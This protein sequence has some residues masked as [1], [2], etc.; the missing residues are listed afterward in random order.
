MRDPWDPSPDEI[1]QWAYTVNAVEPCEDWDLA[2]LWSCH[3]KALLEC[4]SDDHCPNRIYMLRIL[5]LVVG[6]AVRSDFRSRPRPVIDGLI[7]R[8]DSY[9]HPSI[10]LWQQRSRELL[11][12]P[13]SFDYKAWCAGSHDRHSGS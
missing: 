1:R 12:D 4:A 10:R 13:S 8:G 2:L 7:D 6:D 9:E 5:Y 3:E 11:R